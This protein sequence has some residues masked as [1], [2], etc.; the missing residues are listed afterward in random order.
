MTVARRL[1]AITASV[2]EAARTAHLARVL[3]EVVGR[4]ALVEGFE[5]RVQVRR[6]PNGT[7]FDVTGE[8]TAWD[9]PPGGIP[10]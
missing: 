2:P 10:K 7:E 5:L 1:L 8:V 3:E 9:A 6:A 4:L